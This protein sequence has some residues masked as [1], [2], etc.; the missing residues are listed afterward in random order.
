[1]GCLVDLGTAHKEVL[2]SIPELGQSI[3]GF[4]E[5]EIVIT[6]SPGVWKFGGEIAH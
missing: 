2:G 1:M 6:T 4:F 3:I 5:Y